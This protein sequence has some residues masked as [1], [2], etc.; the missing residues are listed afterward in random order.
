MIQVHGAAQAADWNVIN[1]VSGSVL[2]VQYPKL[3]LKIGLDTDTGLDQ[4]CIRSTQ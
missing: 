1:T 4:S 2:S 3:N